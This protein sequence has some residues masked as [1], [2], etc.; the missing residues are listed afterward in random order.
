MKTIQK[1]YFKKKI[2]GNWKA[3]NERG[4]ESIENAYSIRQLN[5]FS[6]WI[7]TRNFNG[8]QLNN[9][10]RVRP[11][12]ATPT[13]TTMNAIVTWTEDET[14]RK[15]KFIGLNMKF[16]AILSYDLNQNLLIW[17]CDLATNG[18]KNLPQ[19]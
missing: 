18:N 17:D 16:I 9:W 8:K 12:T 6:I 7:S 14:K 3:L 15:Y 13:T 11:T 2:N 1:L 4:Q 19:N 5:E 10:A